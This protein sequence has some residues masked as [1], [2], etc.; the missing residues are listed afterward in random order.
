MA[1]QE[2]VY[3]SVRGGPADVFVSGVERVEDAGGGCLRFVLFAW[4]VVDGKQVRA[5][6]DVAIVMP[7]AAVPEGI[8]KSMMALGRKVIARA[9]GSLTVAH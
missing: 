1:C 8:G 7:A 4:R 2:V 6:L 3:G 9:D 5:E